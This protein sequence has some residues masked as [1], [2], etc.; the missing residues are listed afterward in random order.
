MELGIFTNSANVDFNQTIQLY[1]WPI[2][3][4]SEHRTY[5]YY[6]EKK[7]ELKIT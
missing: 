5:H 2:L 4:P 3:K 6:T 7:T 1:N